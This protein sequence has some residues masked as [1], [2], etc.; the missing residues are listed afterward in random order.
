M[1]TATTR[2]TPIVVRAAVV[3]SCPSRAPNTKA[4]SVET[5]ARKPSYFTS[6]AYPST[7]GMP[8]GRSS[9]GR[10]RGRIPPATYRP[11]RESA[12]GVWGRSRRNGGRAPGLDGRGPAVSH[13]TSEG[14]PIFPGPGIGGSEPWH[15]SAAC[16]ARERAADMGHS[17]YRAADPS[18]RTQERAE[19]RPPALAATAAGG[20]A[21]PQGRGIVLVGERTP[22]VRPRCVCLGHRR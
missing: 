16:A 8:P 2:Q 11:E 15:R 5:I 9:I 14:C 3:C 10:G 1:P 19:E 6:N 18:T 7:V 4:S 17:G 20:R 22:D 13:L 21:R 12:P